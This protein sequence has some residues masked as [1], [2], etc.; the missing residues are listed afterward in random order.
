[1][2]EAAVL[3]GT[4]V[5]RSRSPKLTDPSSFLGYSGQQLGGSQFGQ[6]AGQ[7]AQQG[8]FGQQSQFAGGMGQLGAQPQLSK[9]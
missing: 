5:R 6:Q 2:V 3:A 1:M 9:N 8:Q 7:F 4:V